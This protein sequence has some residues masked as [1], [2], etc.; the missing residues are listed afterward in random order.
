MEKRL[1]QRACQSLLIKAMDLLSFVLN[2]YCC[3]YLCTHY[4]IHYPICINWC[5]ASLFIH[6]LSSS[7]NAFWSHRVM[8]W[9]CSFDEKCWKS[10]A[11]KASIEMNKQINYMQRAQIPVLSLDK[12]WIFTL[13]I[14]CKLF[15]FHHFRWG[16]VYLT[17]GINGIQMIS[18][19]DSFRVSQQMNSK[20]FTDLESVCDIMHIIN[21][22]CLHWMPFLSF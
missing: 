1:S 6:D 14:T 8:Q 3:L 19:L 10:I 16:A 22:L 15:V 13:K 9:H 5:L 17:L 4:W 21:R 2:N 18:L 7:L 11:D 12:D 20:V